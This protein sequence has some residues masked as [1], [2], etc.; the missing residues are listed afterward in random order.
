MQLENDDHHAVLVE[1]FETDDGS[2]DG[3]DSRLAFALGVEW[4]MFRGQLMV[5]EMDD[6]DGFTAVCMSENAERFIKM[7]E[8]HGRFCE[9]RRTKAK[10]WSEVWIGGKVRPAV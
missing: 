7:A 1:P 5:C 2:L 3:V 4:A 6:G 10:G 9:S 8:R